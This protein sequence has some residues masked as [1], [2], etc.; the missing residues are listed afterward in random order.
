MSLRKSEKLKA[1]AWFSIENAHAA[2]IKASKR[3]IRHD[4][5][6]EKIQYI[7]GIDV[8]YV[9]RFSIGVATVFDYD[10]LSLLESKFSHVKTRF[11][12]IPTLLSFREIPPAV[13]AIKTLRLKP[14]VFLVDGQGIMHPY[15]LGLASHLGLIINKP[16][17]G[18]AKSPLVGTINK[19]NEEN[20]ALIRDKKEIIGAALLTKENTKPIYVSIGHMISLKKAMEIVRHCIS[21]RRI[22][23]P[24]ALAHRLAT[25]ERR[26]YVQAK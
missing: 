2:Q 22:P 23:E 9:A 18:I 11:P 5:L 10:S 17:I 15:R 16:T 24:I 20:W 4:S 3:I 8:S 21:N 12:Y 13:K 25:Q 14:D 1:P 7:A 6:P 26:K 19:F